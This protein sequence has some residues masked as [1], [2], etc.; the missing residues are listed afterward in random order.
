MLDEGG[1]VMQETRSFNADDDSTFSIRTKEDADD[2][3]YFPDPDLTPFVITE[4]D[5]EKFRK[6]IPKLPEEWVNELVSDFQLPEYDARLMVEDPDLLKYYLSVTDTCKNY[7]A[8]SNFFIGPVKSYCNENG[9]DISSITIPP[10]H[11]KVLIG[12]IDDGRLNFSTAANKLLPVMMKDGSKDPVVLADELNII[13]VSD[14]GN[15][16]AWADEVLN[17][18]PD[19]VNEFRKGKKGLI[20]LFV[21]EVKKISAG[22]A[23]PKLTTEILLQKLN[24][25]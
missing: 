12:M 13:Q 25:S 7:K 15:L 8:V 23:D 20:G 18:M 16:E 1:L 21:G 2:Y 14:S 5:I 19:K 10:D 11:W 22:K 17:K 4:S 9:L 24:Q 3:R 6:E